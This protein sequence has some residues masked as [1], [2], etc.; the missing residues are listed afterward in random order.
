MTE[1][2]E[3]FTGK[4]AEY[5]RYREQYDSGLILSLLR[6]WCGLE[7]EWVVADV[8]IGTGMLAEVFLR[9]GNA[10]FGVEP[11]ADMRDG[12]AR[13]LRVFEQLSLEN[14]SAEA[15]GLAS[16]AF[17]L[18]T[19]GRALHWFDADRAF[20]E[21]HRILR[22]GGWVA[23]IAEGR[24]E[25]GRRENLKLEEL[26]RKTTGDSRSTRE[27]Y[28]VYATLKKRFEPRSFHHEE[29]AGEMRLDWESL[30]GFVQSLSYTPRKED[31]RFAEFQAGLRKFYDAYEVAGELTL[32]TRC[33]VTVGQPRG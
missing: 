27:R 31:A 4:V 11:N 32:A 2:G 10:V 26:L 7:R 19:V 18:V 13:L 22:P 16:D 24:S 28:A 12:C 9:N 5:A 3:R 1:N 15:T 14:G 30:D 17:D 25:G 20:A 29:V 33:W 21:F 23:V 6:R 8:G